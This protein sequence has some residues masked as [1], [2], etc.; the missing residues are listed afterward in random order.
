MSVFIWAFFFYVFRSYGFVDI[1]CFQNALIIS[2]ETI[3]TVGYTV[4]DISFSF[5][6]G[7]HSSADD[8][9]VAFILLYCEMMQSILMNS[10]CIGVVYARFSRALVR[11]QC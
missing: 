7:V 8:Q 6:V 3:T 1:H 11:S 5:A 9:P 2:L 4:T 10:F